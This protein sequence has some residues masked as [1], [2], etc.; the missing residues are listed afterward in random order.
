VSGAGIGG[1]GLE[2]VAKAHTQRRDALRNRRMRL[3]TAEAW[4]A[5]VKEVTKVL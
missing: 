1:E 3:A 4:V 2:L 5:R